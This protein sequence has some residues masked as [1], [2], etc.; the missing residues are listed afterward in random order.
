MR[1]VLL[2]LVGLVFPAFSVDVAL[3]ARGSAITGT[4]SGAKDPVI[5]FLD[6]LR[7]VSS[8]THKHQIAQ[9]NTQFSIKLL[10]IGTGD[11]VAFPNNDHVSHNVFSLSRTKKFDFGIYPPGSDRTVQFQEPGLVDVFCNIHQEMHA[12][13]AVVPSDYYAASDKQGAFRIADVPAGKYTA[14]VWRKGKEVRRQ[15]VVVVAGTD[16]KLELE[17]K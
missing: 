16:A 2:V 14:V 8:A 6:G 3:A 17:L 4:I 5:I 11:S 10:V 12:T 15:A 1:L 7:T 13:I 9:K